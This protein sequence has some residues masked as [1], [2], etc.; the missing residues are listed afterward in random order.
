VEAA[1]FHDVIV[2]EGV[3]SVEFDLVLQI[4][5]QSTNLGRQMNDMRRLKLIK[6]RIR[7]RPRSQI[8]IFRRQEDPSFAI[9]W[10][11]FRVR[12]NGLADEAGSARD[13]DGGFDGAVHVVLGHGGWGVGAGRWRG[14]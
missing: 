2:D 14:E 5:K 7:I 12:F 4:S 3:F 9:L 11:G 10:I 6:N 1:V 8:A 13:E